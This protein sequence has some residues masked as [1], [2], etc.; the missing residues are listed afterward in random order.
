MDQEAGEIA[1][2]AAPHAPWFVVP[3]DNKWFIRLVVV[4]A[5]NDALNRLDLAF[6]DVTDRSRRRA[7]EARVGRLDGRN[8]RSAPLRGIMERSLV[9]SLE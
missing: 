7:R 2:T 4:A 8:S 1:A 5:M 6:P 3:A 9:R